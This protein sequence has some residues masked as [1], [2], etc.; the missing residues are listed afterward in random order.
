MT[1]AFVFILLYWKQLLL[2]YSLVRTRAVHVFP[3]PD[4]GPQSDG[5]GSARRPLR[6]DEH[7]RRSV[8]VWHAYCLFAMTQHRIA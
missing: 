1:C 3:P 7:H 2:R 6:T 8:Q 5:H 4:G